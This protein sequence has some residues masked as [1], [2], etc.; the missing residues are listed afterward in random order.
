MNFKSLKTANYISSINE[1][2]NFRPIWNK[3]S[4]IIE[5]LNQELFDYFDIEESTFLINDFF[6]KDIYSLDKVDI[7]IKLNYPK[8]EEL[9]ESKFFKKYENDN[10]NYHFCVENNFYIYNGFFKKE[11]IIIEIEKLI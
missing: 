5:N 3:I 4:S 6:N 11:N 10:I 7:L 8:F 1:A 9:V 2:K